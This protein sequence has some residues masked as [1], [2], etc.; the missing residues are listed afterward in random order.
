MATTA[1]DPPYSGPCR[2]NRPAARGGG[3]RGRRAVPFAVRC[4]RNPL[5]RVAAVLPLRGD[6]P[7]RLDSAVPV[8]RPRMALVAK[9][10]VAAAVM[11]A[12]AANRTVRRMKKP[13]PVLMDGSCTTPVRPQS[14][15]RWADATRTDAAV[16]GPADVRHRIPARERRLPRVGRART[17]ADLLSWSPDNDDL[18]AGPLTALRDRMRRAGAL[19][20]PMA[21]TDAQNTCL[22]R[23]FMRDFLSCASAGGARAPTTRSRPAPEASGPGHAHR[24]APSPEPPPSVTAPIAVARPV[25]PTS[26][27]TDFRRTVIQGLPTDLPCDGQKRSAST[28]GKLR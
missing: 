5:V 19:L 3:L 18:R 1:P 25:R 23:A 24:Q 28:T 20:R 12:Q 11:R 6:P 13:F 7:P 16:R 15:R 2:V 22:R 27:R 26:P 9:K 21:D 8:Q 17:V 10:P 4:A 14:V